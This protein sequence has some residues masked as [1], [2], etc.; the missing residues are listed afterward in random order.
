MWEQKE[1]RTL[2]LYE[3]LTIVRNVTKELFTQAE[4]VEAEISNPSVA[5]GHCY[6][7]LVELDD[8]GATIALVNAHIWR[9]LYGPLSR[10]FKDQAGRVFENGDKLRL[11]VIPDFSQRYGF[12]LNIVD[13][14]PAFTLGELAA[15]KKATWNRLVKEGLT[16][17]N[18][19]LEVPSLP[20]CVAVV[21]ADGAAGYGDFCKHISQG[22][23]ELGCKFKIDLYEAPMQGNAAPEG[24]RDAFMQINA[25][26]QKYDVVVFIRGGGSDLDLAC[27][28]EYLVCK[29]IAEC[30]YPVISG[31]GHERDNHLCDDVAS[32]RV[33]TPTAAAAFLI[34]RIAEQKGV[35]EDFEQKLF[36][37]AEAKIASQ[38]LFLQKVWNR[39]SQTLNDKLSSA[40]MLLE[41]LKNAVLG[42]YT[43]KLS[44][45]ERELS[46][47]EQKILASDPAKVL[48]KGYGYLDAD[49]RKLTDI[50]TLREGSRLRLKMKDG[51]AEF[52]IKDLVVKE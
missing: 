20:F 8:Q 50:H 40:G 11:K 36:S 33:K 41:Q 38:E 12:S 46:V 1:E 43:A 42:S 14:D 15:K 5:G 29:A 35:I 26:D 18:K 24:I 44:R 34:D 51:V 48:E 13:I 47:L 2:K 23:K 32:E 37:A 28:D 4:W 45:E 22:E 17:L 10:K 31:I 7:D 9:S 30:N 21:S 16:E 27:F 52:T 25:A 3:F 6:M 19:E 39:F 49:G